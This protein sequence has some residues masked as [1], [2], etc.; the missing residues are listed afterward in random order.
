MNEPV[1]DNPFHSPAD[2]SE[3]EA[4]AKT[5]MRNALLGWMV[6]VIGAMC[7]TQCFFLTGFA[8]QRAFFVSTSLVFGISLFFGVRCTI[9]AMIH[10]RQ[11]QR[12]AQHIRG[13]MVANLL[14]VLSL[15]ALVT[16][17]TTA[18]QW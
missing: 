15:I 16:G 3:P 2:I 10:G 18:V 4:T 13:A 11:N 8:F 17:A 1:E 12:A 5:A 7:A 9:Y 6:P 14:L